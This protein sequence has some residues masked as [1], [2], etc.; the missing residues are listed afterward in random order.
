MSA[1]CQSCD[2][3]LP[4][5][6]LGGLC[7]RCVGRNAFGAEAPDESVIGGYELI[8]ELGRGGAGVV[9]LARQIELDRLVA[10]KVLVAGAHAGLAAD[11]RF[12]REARE[13]ARLRHP[14]I[15]AI[16][17]IGR[18]EG[19]PFYSMD[20][21]E[22]EDLSAYVVRSRP[23]L[24]E[25][26][27]ISAQAAEAVQHAH[28]HGVLHRDLKPGNLIVD[29]TGI[30]HLT[31]FGLATTVDGSDGLTRT[32]EVMGTPGYVAPE[33]LRGESSIA[34]DVYGLGA[35][36][37][38]LL[39]GRAPFVAA[40]LPE[41][42][43]AVA[44]GDPLPPR[45]LDPSIPRDLET[46][47][48]RA[49]A[50][51]PANRY[52]TARAFAEDLERWLA[53]KPIDARPISFAERAWR[54][55]QRNKKLTAL[56][57]ALAATALSGSVGILSQWHRAEAAAADRLANL[58][59]ADLKVAS[60]ALL[61]GDLST[62][63]RTLESCPPALRDAAWG[64][65]WPQ[66][67]GDAESV[68]G[69]STWT[70]TDLAVSPDGTMAAAA[71]QV[72]GVRLWDL[73]HSR[74]L[75]VLPGTAT[76]WWV[77][78]YPDGRQLFTAD[79]TV[80]QWDV[81]T[82]MLLREFPGQSGAL[83]P[84]GKTL[85]TCAG[86]RFIYEGTPGVVA[87]WN[88]ADGTKLFEL[89]GPARA[90]ALSHDGTKLAVSDAE[91]TITLY[92][93]HDGRVLIPAWSSQ[94]RLWHLGFSPDDRT[95]VASGWSPLVRLW[96]LDNVSAAPRQLRHPLNTWATAFSPDGRQVAVACSDRLVYVWDVQTWSEH[97]TLR[98]HDHEAWS[99][100][101]QPDGRLLS[102]GR[103]PRVLRWPL[104]SGP[105]QPRVR[106]DADSFQ[107][108]WLPGNRLATSRTT[109]ANGDVA[110]I[111]SL[112]T[113]NVRQEF[114]GET[115]LAFDAHSNRLWLWSY[116]H[117]LFA[118]SLD[119]IA[120]V[121][122]TIDWPLAKGETLVDVPRVVPRA[123]LAWAQLED[124]SLDLRRL[125]NGQRLPLQKGIFSPRAV[126]GAALSPDGQWFVWGGASTELQI[127]NLTTGKRARL[128]GHR[129]D[130]ASVLFAPDG[131][132]FVSGG[133]D[134]LLFVW[135]TAAPHRR[136][137]LGRHLTSV[138][139]LAFSPDG[140]VLASQEAGIGIHL[141]HP[142]TG[143]EIGFLPVADEGNGQ[144]LGF[145]PESDR[146]ALRLSTGEIQVFPISDQPN[147]K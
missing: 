135:E 98:G 134:G 31:D 16:H 58:Y 4:E 36:L 106:H 76:S 146:L 45:R 129:Y 90:I 2:A 144:W 67:S 139:Q 33:Q 72:D 95:L 94:G 127:L 118:R 74:L 32:G 53:G 137:E 65:L 97:R 99:L 114:P 23:G 27:S 52:P 50:P 40:R 126:I 110:S 5:S 122:T 25:A 46:I 13:A 1:R 37:Y 14:H 3:A 15:V 103:D 30:P 81:A 141:W 64:L 34:T 29:P 51:S 56:T 71:A 80:K 47:A 112:R 101:W 105:P 87:A 19:R 68:V 75:G 86:H 66:T 108:S 113:P 9:Y 38:F 83:S 6:M 140:R 77:A 57:L 147:N 62:A 88:V 63:R 132:S 10:L 61:T 143:R 21:I 130:V 35:V 133:A 17:E 78:F 18:H 93:A 120:D 26:A 43:A 41:L 22:G 12:M 116:T 111:A 70:V 73:T 104:E 119:H 24:R 44:A 96:V 138:G 107:I 59:S 82:R 142:A 91:S 125:S 69:S 11:E 121:V 55:S 79:H 48:L 124:G 117:Q 136:R 92:D 60:N 42:I 7:P 100:A 85:F 128:E 84:D 54:W 123:G 109:A 102:A 49:L 39:T 131:K 145:S 28:D 8:R 20:F 89:P 115:P